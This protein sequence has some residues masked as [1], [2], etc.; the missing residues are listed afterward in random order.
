[1]RAL[2]TKKNLYRARVHNFLPLPS[3]D[4]LRRKPCFR[5]ASAENLALDNIAVPAVRPGFRVSS[6]R[7]VAGGFAFTGTRTPRSCSSGRRLTNVW[8]KYPIMRSLAQFAI[9]WCTA[10]EMTSSSRVGGA[11]ANSLPLS[12]AALSPVRRLECVREEHSDRH[13]AD[14]AR[15]RRD[16]AGDLFGLVERYVAHHLGVAVRK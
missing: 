1:M 8:P 16:E 5:R 15:H 4:S 12:R 9:A 10:V 11:L 2:D 13:G 6:Q 7:R 3:A 14:A